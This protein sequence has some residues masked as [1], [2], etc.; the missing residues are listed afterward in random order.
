MAGRS[1][2]RWKRSE[3]ET[4]RAFGTERIPNNGFGQ[5]DFVVPAQ[6][7]NPPIAC[8][9]KT[10]ADLPGWFRDAVAQASLDAELMEGDAVP[11]VVIVHS[12]GQGIP[13]QRYMVLRLEDAVMLLT[14]SRK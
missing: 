11:A 12:P 13:R 10:K 5:P 3:I 6:G 2:T 1:R 4:A 14:E 7:D 8:Q 9:V